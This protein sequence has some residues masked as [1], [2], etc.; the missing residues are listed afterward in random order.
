MS[1]KLKA[2]LGT[3]GILSCLIAL[4][5]L[6]PQTASAFV[7]P[8]SHRTIEVDGM[9]LYLVYGATALIIIFGIVSLLTRGKVSSTFGGL[10]VAWAFLGGGFLTAIGAFE[11]LW[12]YSLPKGYLHDPSMLPFGIGLIIFGIAIVIGVIVNRKREAF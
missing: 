10:S 4:Y 11:I 1:N 5:M 7:Y 9:Y 12:D 2:V 6:L 3:G 8:S